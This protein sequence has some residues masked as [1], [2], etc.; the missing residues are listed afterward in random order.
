MSAEVLKI[1]PAPN[2][3]NN[4]VLVTDKP[5]DI[6]KARMARV[7]NTNKDPILLTQTDVDGRFVGNILI[8]G[9]DEIA[10]ELGATD[11]IISN[12]TSGVFASSIVARV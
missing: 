12:V 5:N 2:K 10:I 11:S 7:V 3:A 8:L 9:S 1:V 4:I 6:F